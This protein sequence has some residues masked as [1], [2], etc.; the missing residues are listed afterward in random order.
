[1]APILPGITDDPGLLRRTAAAAM[2]AG[3]THVYPILLHLRP[4][5]K[6][7]FMAWLDSEHPG[8]VSRYEAMYG[9]RAYAP[10]ADQQK[11]AGA[12]EA[13]LGDLPAP[14]ATV[15]RFSGRRWHGPVER[16]PQPVAEQLAL[17]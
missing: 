4:R 12:M 5:V 3:A 11:L 16:A 1:M 9:D 10:R 2:D 6:E 7:E 17:V 8:M 14:R 13:I 15:A